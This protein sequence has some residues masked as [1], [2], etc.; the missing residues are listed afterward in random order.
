MPLQRFIGIIFTCFSLACLAMYVISAEQEPW[1]FYGSMTGI[2]LVYSM[3]AIF[4]GLPG[5]IVQIV[6]L[7]VLSYVVLKLNEERIFGMA[8]MIIAYLLCMDY[9]FYFKHR[10]LR[11]V[12]TALVALVI[13]LTSIGLSSMSVGW[14]IFTATFLT[15]LWFIY[16]DMAKKQQEKTLIAAEKHCIR[17]AKLN[18]R[19]E[20]LTRDS[21]KFTKE[22]IEDKEQSEDSDG[23]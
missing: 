2:A 1:W 22:L 5:K 17:Y 9:G 8:A 10:I 16:L 19:Y 14:C 20:D 13:M 15:M 4:I 21:L 3:S 23:N 6:G 18:K 11:L 7:L 12:I